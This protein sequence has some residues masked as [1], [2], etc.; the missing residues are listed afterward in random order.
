V[1]V[2]FLAPMPPART[3]VADYAQSLL[4]ALSARCDVRLDGAG[5][6]ICLYHL[7]N[8]HLHADIYRK[9]LERPGVVVLHD[10]VLNHF[11]LGCLDRGAYID[12][13]VYNYGEFS[14]GL[15]GDLWDRRAT[16]ATDP[17][18]FEYA[19]IRRVAETSCAIVVHNPAA[20]RIV[21]R[22]APGACVAEI[23]HLFCP[24][25]APS[26]AEVEHWRVSHGIP[27]S[28]FLF[29]IFGYLREPKRLNSVLRAFAALAGSPA[30]LL[31]AGEFA[32][33]TLEQALARSRLLEAPGIFRLEFLPQPEFRLATSAVDACINLRFPSAGETSGITVRLMGLG[34]PVIVTA[35]EENSAFPAGAVIRVDPGVAEQRM[36]AEYMEWLAACRDSAREI[37]RCAA[38]HI[39]E[40]HSL[41]RV[42]DQYLRILQSC[43]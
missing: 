23:P 6:G 13:F 41:D 36:L 38:A 14:R 15:A 27:A 22:H 33:P 18:Y 3:G 19:M 2:G 40:N 9:A 25:E 4:E 11:F 31:I 24:S 29:A 17:R 39:R 32:S 34:K 10:A 12:E 16:S 20:A 8:N 21:K 37:G 7:G 42:A 5:A 1:T 28:V 30:A 35:S 26:A 43:C